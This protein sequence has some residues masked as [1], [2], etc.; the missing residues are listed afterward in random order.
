MDDRTM[1]INTMIS[2]NKIQTWH[3]QI[4]TSHMAYALIFDNQMKTAM[5]EG[6]LFSTMLLILWHIYS[7]LLSINQINIYNDF[8]A[9][10][11]VW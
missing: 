10:V 1:I 5:R 7:T 8:E 9:H 4:D 11:Q 3:N 6:F 2:W